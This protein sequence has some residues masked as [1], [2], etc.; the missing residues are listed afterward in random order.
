[1]FL[2]KRI[3]WHTSRH[4]F[5]IVITDIIT[6]EMYMLFFEQILIF[7]LKIYQFRGITIV[8]RKIH[9]LRNV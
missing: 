8:L 2:S 3:C 6:I 9:L 7:A 1:M 4:R 5:S